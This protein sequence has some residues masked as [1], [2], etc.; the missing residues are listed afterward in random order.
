A[1]AVTSDGLW[2]Q[3]EGAPRF[4]PAPGVEREIW[5]LEVAAEIILDD[6]VALVDR[7]DERELVHILEDGAILVVHHATVSSPIAEPGDSAEPSAFRQ[8]LDGEIQLVAGNEIDVA[9]RLQAV[10]RVDRDLRPD[11]TDQELGID[12]LKRADRLEIS[13]ERRRG[14]VQHHEVADAR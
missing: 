13:G 6:Q 5:V 12:A 14:G 2:P 10:L 3:A 7:R 8:L 1:I 9:T 11:E 4:A